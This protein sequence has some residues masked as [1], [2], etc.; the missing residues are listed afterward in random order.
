MTPEVEAALA[1]VD[2]EAG[3]GYREVI[4]QIGRDGWLT[5]HWPEEFGDRGLSR[6]ESYIFF[7]ETAR[8]GVPIRCSRRTA[9]GR[10]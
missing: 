3:P 1:A 6:V 10:R 4:A 5:V 2:G 8:L 7:D 9:W